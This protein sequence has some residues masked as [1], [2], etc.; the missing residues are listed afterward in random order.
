VITDLRPKPKRQ[1]DQFGATEETLFAR[2]N[3]LAERGFLSD[4]KILFLGDYDLTSLA[5]LPKAKNTEIWALDVDHEVLRV[6]K[7]Q[8]K[9]A[10][11]TVQHNLTSLLPHRLLSSFDF[12]FTDPPYTPEG[13]TLFL[14]RALQA[15]TKGDRARVALSYGSLDPVRILALQGKIL[16]HGIVIEEL[17]PGFN[18]YLAAKTIGDVSDLYVLRPTAKVRPLV[19]GGY[20]GKIY[21][22]E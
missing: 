9:G 19:R 20:A 1:F 4:S 17:R 13:V 11:F 3:L 5:C 12:I 14:S 8:S 16:E 18:E 6:I 7:E 2:A 10:V 21:T 15:L 22:F